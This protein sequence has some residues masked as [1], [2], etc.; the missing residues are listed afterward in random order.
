[1]KERYLGTESRARLV[2][3]LREQKLMKDGAAVIEDLADIVEILEVSQNTRLIEE[4]ASDSELYFILSGK[5]GIYVKGNFVAYRGVGDSVGEM[6]AI[7][8]SIPRS[9]DVIAIELS[10]VAKISSGDFHKIFDQCPTLWRNVARELAKRLHQRNGALQKPNPKSEV[11]IISSVE[12]LD[13]A[14]EIQTV[15]QHD[16]LITCWTDGVF[17][18]S[19]Y[20]LDSLEAKVDT[21]DFA[22]AVVQPDDITTMPSRK[23]VSKVARDN[24]IFELGLFM[25]RIGRKRTILF[26]PRGQELKLPTDLLGITT[27]SYQVGRP[28]DLT[29]HIAT[30]CNEARK[31]IKSMGVRKS[32]YGN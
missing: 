20:P 3:A 25:G 19:D 30:A 1:M 13:V 8:H 5:F 16:A 7:E 9:A 10:V 4:D 6:S 22:V 28:Q 31:V 12:A 17:F 15:L 2:D 29:A 23:I 11:F 32:R 26:Q 27:I 21:A 14:R 18:A 24:V